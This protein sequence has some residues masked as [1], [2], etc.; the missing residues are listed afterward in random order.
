MTQ[1]R[2]GALA[3]LKDAFK[4][5]TMRQKVP[6]FVVTLD[7]LGTLYRF[8]E[9]VA[10][11]YRT[12]AQQCGLQADI[13]SARLDAAFRSAFKHYNTVYPNYGKG[14]LRDPEAWWTKLVNRAFRNLVDVDQQ[15]IPHD[16]GPRLYQHFSSGEAYELYPDVQPFLHTLRMLKGQFGGPDGPLIATGV[17]TNS[18][19]RVR[20]VLQDL[21]LTAGPSSLPRLDFGQTIAETASRFRNQEY[22]A[23]LASPFV[24]YFAADNDFDFLCTS[25]EAGAE[26]PDINVWLA[27]RQLIIPIPGSRAEQAVDT[28][29]SAP[30]R[31][32]TECI[33]HEVGDTAWIHIG[34]EYSKDYVGAVG[35]DLDALLLRRNG[36]R[37]SG[38]SSVAEDEDSVKSVSSLEEAAMV[39]SVMVQERFASGA[40]TDQPS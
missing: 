38:V 7:A 6:V 22:R 1:L 13:D 10:V 14:Q 36:D 40:V 29:T 32:M 33:R 34:D 3:M 37:D 8:R 28:S 19:P 35:A 20:S 18:D 24:D 39:V 25:Y 12:V 11:Q 26:K 21:G 17:V 5:L 27:A 31:G 16:L 9:P 15:H 23:L 30:H 4:A 2:I